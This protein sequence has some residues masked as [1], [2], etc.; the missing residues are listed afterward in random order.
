MVE[1]VY[2]AGLES[3]G[4]DHD[5]PGERPYRPGCDAVLVPILTGTTSGCLSPSVGTERRFRADYILR[6]LGRAELA[7]PLGVHARHTLVP[8]TSPFI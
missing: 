4:K 5:A 7:G 8:W 6:L 2:R 1:P 3:G